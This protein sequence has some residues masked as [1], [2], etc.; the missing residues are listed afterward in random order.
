MQALY[1]F[2]QCKEAN[3]QRCIE[4]IEEAYLPDLNSMEPQDKKQLDK[5]KKQAISL[6]KKKFSN[7]DTAEFPN[8][9]MKELLIAERKFYYTQVEKDFKFLKKQILKEV[10]DIYADYI[11]A[12]ALLIAFADAAKADK[13]LDHGNFVKSH[14]ITVLKK[15]DAL[16]QAMLKFS[17]WETNFTEVRIWFRDLVKNNDTYLAFLDKRSPDESDELNIL[18]HISRKIVLSKGPIF[19]YFE[20]KDLYWAENRDIVKS[21]VDKTLKSYKPGENK[22]IQ[23]QTLSPNWEEDKQFFADLF[24]AAVNLDEQYK[25]LI[26]KNTRNW[27]VDRLPLTD[28][29][30]L[31][32]A[33]AE[34]LNF[35]NIP[36]KVTINE[37]IELSKKY[38]TDKSRQF[39]NGILDVITKKMQQS[40]N[41]KKSGR[42]LI[43]NK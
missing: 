15:D 41:L 10:E 12:L 43:D 40:G 22:S 4:R 14:R 32:L 38:S 7:L 17:K 11:E 18:I 13:K 3:F 42:G 19:D 36:V 34:V 1:A 28:R 5:D 2:E 16:K 8:D 9:K 31:E 24:V 23:L 26:A 20:S 30:I 37:Y 39:V 35:P 27:E 33:L 21:L 6:F 29:V 25:D